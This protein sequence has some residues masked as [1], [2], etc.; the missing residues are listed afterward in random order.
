MGESEPFSPKFP[1][2]SPGVETA[3]AAREAC[4]ASAPVGP[5]ESEPFSPKFPAL[6]REGETAS[7][8]RD[9]YG[10]GTPAGRG[11]K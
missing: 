3:S 8:A 1:A 5:G 7:A 2:L 4:G 9:G 11:G 10:A 6:S